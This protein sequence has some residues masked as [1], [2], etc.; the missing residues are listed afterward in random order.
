[1]GLDLTA[2]ASNFRERRGELLP[3]ATLRFDRDSGLF[4]QLQVDSTPSLVHLLPEGLRVGLY[5]DH[6]LRY[7]E[8]DRLGNRLTW[9]TSHELKQLV[10]SDEI[11]P[12][13]RAIL[14]F[15][16]TLNPEARIVLVWG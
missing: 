8:V 12:W 15:L 9:T 6:G 13:N 3:T 11:A 2:V 1:M 16:T 10:I 5:E 4:E 7:V 14:A